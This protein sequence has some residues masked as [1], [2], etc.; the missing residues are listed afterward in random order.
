MVQQRSLS[1]RAWAELALLSLIWGGA[2]LTVR[3][4]LDEIPVFTAVAHRVAW[5]ALLLWAIVWIRG[6]AIPRSARVWGALAV[7]GVLNNA[8]PFSLLTWAQLYIESGLTSIFNAATAIFSAVVAAIVFRDE[9]LTA[10][11]AIGVGLGFLG[12]VVAIGPGVLTG[13][14]LRS[15][16]QFAALGAAVSYALAVAWGRIQLSGLPPLSTA[17][18]MLTCSSLIMVPVAILVEGPPRF[19]LAP[20][21]WI[22]V[23]FYAFLATALAY[24]LY[25]RVLA[26]AGAANLA[27]CTLM[28]PPVAIVAGAVVLGEALPPRA[29]VGFAILALGLL[30]LA[31]RIPLKS[32]RA[33]FR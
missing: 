15:T 9:R 23:G 27:L 1:P 21:T 31:G 4:A 2:F 3:I 14:D 25:Y 12:V 28:I 10:S 20:I 13:L 18:G 33:L 6:D 26:M 30:V 5:A 16:A 7:M 22:S 29:F 19:D 17:A 32:P 11:R 8:L 24:V